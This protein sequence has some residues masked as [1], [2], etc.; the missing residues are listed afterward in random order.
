[1]D[2]KTVCVC[3]CVCVCVYR[4][5]QIT[6]KYTPVLFIARLRRHT[7][8]VRD[9]IKARRDVTRRARERE[10]GGGRRDVR[11]EGGGR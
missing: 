7:E 10:R 6:Y 9:V 11:E 1:M 2:I 3:V 5:H 4:N 8:S